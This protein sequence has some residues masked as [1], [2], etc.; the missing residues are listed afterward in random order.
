MSVPQR[1]AEYL[2]S[3]HV[4]FERL[5]H[6]QAFAAQEVAYSLHISGK[7]LAKAVVLKADDNPVMVVLPAS[8]RL[9]IKDLRG[10]LDV[11][12]LEMTSETELAAI[13]PDC[14][15]GAIPPFGN[16]YGMAVWVDQAC[17]DSEEIVFCAGSH[18]DCL[19]MKYSDYAKAVSPHTGRFSA[20]WGTAAA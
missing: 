1:I 7:Q 15:L 2:E 10:L 12:R 8:H 14:E 18:I 6:P 4:P 3:Q 13:F 5:S 20:L 9:S 11:H 19:R 17:S 16:L